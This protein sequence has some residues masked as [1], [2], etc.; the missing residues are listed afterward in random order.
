M[1]D[2]HDTPTH[3]DDPYGWALAQA[4]AIRALPAST[5][6]FDRDG[7]IE[8]LEES[9]HA[10]IAAVKIALI[11]LMAGLARPAS[12]RSPAVIGHWRGGCCHPHQTILLKYRSSMRDGID[13]ECLWRF[14]R[15]DVIASFADHGEPAPILPADCP[16][17]LAQLV[18][19]D[20]DIAGTVESLRARWSGG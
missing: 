19:E 18:D 11:R 7:L 8:F 3:H 6:A 4:E 17:T 12:T 2:G 10:A 13:M 9:A 5:M 16:F 15:K 1:P 14:A 20:L